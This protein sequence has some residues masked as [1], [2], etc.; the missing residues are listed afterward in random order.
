MADETVSREAVVKRLK[1]IEGQ[2]RG[3]QRLIEDNRECEA[4]ITQFVAVRSAI[5]STASLILSNYT[6]ICF[7]K[8]KAAERADVESLARAIAI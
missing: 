3:I 7:G 8:D 6:K 1:R 2:I 5:E 4:V